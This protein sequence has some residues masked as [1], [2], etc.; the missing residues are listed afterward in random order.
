MHQ[1]NSPL[2]DGEIDMI[3]DLWFMVIVS[4]VNGSNR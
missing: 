2:I 1:P 3:G 4:V